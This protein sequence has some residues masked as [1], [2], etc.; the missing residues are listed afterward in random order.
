LRDGKAVDG[1][2]CNV[3]VFDGDYFVVVVNAYA[4]NITR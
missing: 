4:M 3:W 2:K 1:L